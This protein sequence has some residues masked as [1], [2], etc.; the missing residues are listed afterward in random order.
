MFVKNSSEKT[1][2]ELFLE[3]RKT[4]SPELR[5]EIVE[6][7]LYIAEYLARR[8][9]G[10]GVEID[11]LTQVASYALVMAVTRYDPEKGAKFI[12]FATP[13]IIGE[14]KKHFRD[15]M[16]SLKVPRRLKEISMKITTLKDE[17]YETT[18]RVPT[19]NELSE[20]MGVSTEDILNA[21]ESG[22]S[23]STYSL[24]NEQEEG[25]DGSTSQFE[26]FLG[27][28]EEGYANF[29]QSGV[30]EKVMEHLSPREKEIIRQ[31][32]VNEITQQEVAAALGVSQMTISRIEKTMKEK[33]KREYNR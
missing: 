21:I 8:Y 7:N 16:W 19:V 24:D 15:T 13:T 6:R 25:E 29:E 27:E 23:Y 30:L 31:R 3:Y 20:I 11:D 17:I 1:T 9:M 12:T 5:N 22:R 28:E 26:K 10:R 33:F 14:I 4:E 32:F 2:E 18:G